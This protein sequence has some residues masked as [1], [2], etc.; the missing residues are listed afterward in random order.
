MTRSGENFG[1]F[2]EF[3]GKSGKN[4]C[5]FEVV[6]PRSHQRSLRIFR[7]HI[8]PGLAQQEVGISVLQEFSPKKTREKFLSQHSELCFPWICHSFPSWDCPCALECSGIPEVDP[9]PASRSSGMWMELGIPPKSF[10]LL[11]E[12]GVLKDKRNKSLQARLREI[13]CRR[14]SLIPGFAAPQSLC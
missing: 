11:Q 3:L 7:S 6:Q 12:S 5:C 8:Q 14:G 1:C 10:L 4:S 13:P 9:C 2:G